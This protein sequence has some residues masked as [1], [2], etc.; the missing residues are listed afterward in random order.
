[1]KKTIEIL[2]IL[3]YNVCVHNVIVGWCL[4]C[5]ESAHNNQIK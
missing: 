2:C 1:M 3:Y 4:Y 5:W